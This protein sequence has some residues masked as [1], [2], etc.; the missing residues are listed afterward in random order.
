[1]IPSIYE[2]PSDSVSELRPAIV[3]SIVKERRAFQ[4]ENAASSTFALPARE[5]EEEKEHPNKV[6]EC[7]RKCTY[8]PPPEK[9]LKVITPATQP[10]GP[11]SPSFT[12]DFSVIY[13]TFIERLILGSLIERV[14]LDSLETHL[15]CARRFGEEIPLPR[16]FNFRYGV[17]REAKPGD[18]NSKEP[19]H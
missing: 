12:R 17:S 19:I 6:N 4:M 16:N 18:S 8:M 11:V 3:R 7:M 9:R 5:G 10:R 14:Q 13:I 15:L 2:Q 1:M